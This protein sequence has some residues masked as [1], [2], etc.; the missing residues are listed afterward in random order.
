GRKGGTGVPWERGQGAPGAA[1]VNRRRGVLTEMTELRD[2]V[3][4]IEASNPSVGAGVAIGRR[5]W[6]GGV[7]VLG[8]SP[9]RQGN[10]EEDDLMPAVDRVCRGAGV[11][12]REIGVVAVSVGPGG[13]TAVRVAAA[14]GKM[15]AEGVAARCIAVPTTMVAAHEATAEWDSQ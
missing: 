6:G 5:R 8:V 1:G 12:P 14:A 2:I 3:L 11:A 9:V 10:R 7:E 13:Y 15:I 4:A